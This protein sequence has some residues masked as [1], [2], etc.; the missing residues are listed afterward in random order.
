MII[1]IYLFVDIWFQISKSIFRLDCFIKSILRLDC[2]IGILFN[3]Y[4]DFINRNLIAYATTLFWLEFINIPLLS[5]YFAIVYLLNHILLLFFKLNNDRLILIK[6]LSNLAHYWFQ[7]RRWSRSIRRY[8]L[9]VI[10]YR[11][12]RS[13]LRIPVTKTSLLSKSHKPSARWLI[14]WYR[15]WWYLLWS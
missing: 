12:N 14:L 5:N 3:F 10:Y 6:L 9:R 7:K 13:S 2:F 4:L 8:R 11:S 1:Y 15:L